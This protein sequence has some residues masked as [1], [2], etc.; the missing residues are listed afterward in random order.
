VV[1]YTSS[2]NPR[3]RERANELGASQYIVKP[4]LIN[5]I[6][7]TLQQSIEHWLNRP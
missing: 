4:S 7:A 1:I 2:E 6:A 3:E 5:E